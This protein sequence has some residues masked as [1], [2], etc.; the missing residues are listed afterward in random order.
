M[1]GVCIYVFSC[2]IDTMRKW[3]SKLILTFHAFTFGN[4]ASTNFTAPSEE[5]VVVLP[6]LADPLESSVEIFA[7]SLVLDEFA[8]LEV[9][10]SPANIDTSQEGDK[11]HK[12]IRKKHKHNQSTSSK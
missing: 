6:A 11:Y 2:H 12:Q 5:V 7:L 4:G 8:L 3:T 10:L 9:L 1:D